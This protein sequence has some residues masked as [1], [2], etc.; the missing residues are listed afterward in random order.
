MDLSYIFFNAIV[1]GTVASC[2][3]SFF[4]YA[5]FL[6]LGLGSYMI[7]AG[8]V[9]YLFVQW[10]IVEASLLLL[11]LIVSYI[12][13]YTLMLRDFSHEKQRDLVALITSLM[14]GVVI[15]NIIQ[16]FFG[17]GAIFLSAWNVSA[18][19]LG[20]IFILVS[21]SVYYIFEKSCYSMIFK[22]LFE[23]YATMQS[24]GIPISTYMHVLYVSRFVGFVGIAILL[25]HT[26]GLKAV[27]GMFYL[28]KWLAIVIMVW[29]AHKQYIFVWALLYVLV[30]Y[31]LFLHLWL[32]IAY[33]E[34]MIMVVILLVLL[35][36]PQG[37]FSIRTRTL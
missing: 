22:W 2:M 15:A 30:E 24:L 11:G 36:K 14:L 28:L 1:Y 5:K 16:F 35:V 29:I 17:S 8:F 23:K 32:P 20:A 13:F 33:K 25:L 18:W 10:H 34:S 3:A 12:A 31:F 27:D 26:S 4:A 37:L 6:H 9:I 21:L 7:G 19:L